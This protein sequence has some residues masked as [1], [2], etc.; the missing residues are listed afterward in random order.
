MRHAGWRSRGYLPHCDARELVQH[1]I[2]GLADAM[3]RSVPSRLTDPT[4]R[5]AWAD[6][7]FDAGHGARILV[8]PAY[9][10]IVEDALPHGA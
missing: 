2:F 7:Q 3:P 1:I 6:K 10:Q 9:A 4:Q 5:G 8:N